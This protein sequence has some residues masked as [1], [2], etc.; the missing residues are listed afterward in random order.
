M[1]GAV[2]AKIHQEALP[3][4]YCTVGGLVYPRQER[5]AAKT[6]NPSL[7][8]HF[9]LSQQRFE[10]QM[11]KHSQLGKGYMNKEKKSMSH[12]GKSRKKTT[13][14]R[15]VSAGSVRKWCT[16]A[17]WHEIPSFKNYRKLFIRSSFIF[18]M[19]KSFTVLF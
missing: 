16:W 18:N 12:S 9:T 1:E 10:K 17:G 4:Q 13:R 11:T 14:S 2:R 3:A 19:V 7:H 8:I 5:Q 15:H 6:A